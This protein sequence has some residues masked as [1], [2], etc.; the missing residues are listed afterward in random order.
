MIRFSCF[1]KS[2]HPRGIQ[3]RDKRVGGESGCC[4]R[5]SRRVGMRWEPAAVRDRQKGAYLRPTQRPVEEGWQRGSGTHQPLFIQVGP[6]RVRTGS[7]THRWS[8]EMP[9]GWHS[10]HHVACA[11]WGQLAVLLPTETENLSVSWNL[12]D[13]D[14]GPGICWN[15]RAYSALGVI[16]T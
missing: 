6:A 9:K 5:K 8:E 3:S 2:W 7:R 4:E 11:S 12:S 10:Q 15:W 14:T 16:I 1:T 13:M